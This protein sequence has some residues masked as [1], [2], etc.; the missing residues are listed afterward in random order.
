MDRLEVAREAGD[1]VDPEGVE[2]DR[3][4]KRPRGE[5]S[6]DIEAGPS[7]SAGSPG[8]DSGA[9]PF[10]NSGLVNQARQSLFPDVDFGPFLNDASVEWVDLDFGGGTHQ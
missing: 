9:A 6:A 7:Q 10:E 5:P 8:A 4:T 1:P 3:R 2:D